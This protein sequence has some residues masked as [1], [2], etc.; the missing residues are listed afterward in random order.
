MDEEIRGD[1]AGSPHKNRIITNLIIIK[2][3]ILSTPSYFCIS[4][5]SKKNKGIEKPLEL[6]GW[7]DGYEKGVYF[8]YGGDQEELALSKIR[9]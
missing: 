8:L 1:L 2:S 4:P 6:Y 5:D 3:N 7:N 9:Y